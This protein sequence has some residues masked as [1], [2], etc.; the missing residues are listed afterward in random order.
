MKLRNTV[1]PNDADR[2]LPSRWA[3]FTLGVAL[4]ILSA[5]AEKQ[6]SLQSRD[7]TSEPTFVGRQACVPCHA[8]AYRK[9]QGSHHD[10]AMDVAT[11]STVLG[12]FNGTEF[13]GEGMNA[14]FFR[15]DGRFFVNTQ[16]PDG[17]AT[18][19][20]V[21]HVFGVEPLQQY[22]IPFPE[23]R[24]QALSV[25]WDVDRRRWFHLYP[26]QNIAPD[27]WLH[28]TRAG[29]NWNGMCAV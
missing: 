28:W 7:Q 18:D 20:E 11:D 4:L 26:G 15:R 3:T 29:Q 17:A 25:A 21:T 5:C 8:D 2:R 24:L 6:D 1:Y 14:R 9:W 16:G 13:E 22:L 23:G 12:D 27:D 19:F 10:L